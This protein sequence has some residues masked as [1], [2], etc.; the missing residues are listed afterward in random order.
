[1]RA[2]I[3]RKLV[4]DGINYYQMFNQVDDFKPDDDCVDFKNRNKN[5]T[6]GRKL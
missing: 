1:M 5:N 3:F 6:F 4:I 2:L